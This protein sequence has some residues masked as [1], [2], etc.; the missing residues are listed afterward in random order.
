VEAGGPR[1]DDSLDTAIGADIRRLLQ[2]EAGALGLGPEE[3]YDG[4]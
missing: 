1:G 4:E 2:S 3:A